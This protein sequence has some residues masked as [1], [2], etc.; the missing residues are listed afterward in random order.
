MGI[1]NSQILAQELRSNRFGVRSLLR[2]L[3]NIRHGQ[4]SVLLPNGSRQVFTGEQA[5]PVASLRLHHPLRLMLRM[6]Q[7]G[8][9]GFAEA[10]MAREWDSGDLGELLHLLA[11]NEPYLH[12]GGSRLLQWLDRLQHRLRRND[13]RGSRRNIAYHYDLGNDFYRLWLDPTMTYS[14]ALFD[15]PGEALDQAQQRKYRQILAQLDAKPGSHLLEI[16][17]GWGGF[18]EYAARQGYRITGITLSQEQLAFA[19]ER[20]ERAGLNG[21][22]ELRLQDYR[23]LDEQFD[24]LVS[25][26]MFEAVGEIY[27]PRYFDTVRRCL[28][29]GG[30]ASLQVITI[31]HDHFTRYRRRTDFIQKYIFPGGMLPSVPR[32]NHLA[33]QAALRVCTQ[34]FHGHDYATTLRHWDQRFGAA[35]KSVIAQGF[36]ERFLRMWHYYL[37]YC[38]AGFRSGRIDLMQ[39]ALEA[40]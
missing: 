14:A 7:H 39:V 40:D 24:H 36:D 27:W 11:V 10:Y 22:V 30:R 12:Q 2:S 6:L 32:F 26:E 13:L 8:D 38:E 3:Q 34:R 23:Q 25:I 18:A 37:A 19:R 35:A 20:I 21:R 5:G 17:C 28:R 1:D 9:I 31:A 16:G 33:E 4:L 15:S 29:P